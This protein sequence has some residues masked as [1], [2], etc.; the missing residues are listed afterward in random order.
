MPVGGQKKGQRAQA[1]SCEED[2]AWVGRR[3]RGEV[4]V[5]GRLAAAP[6]VLTYLCLGRRVLNIQNQLL[7][8]CLSGIYKKIKRLLSLSKT[9]RKSKLSFRDR[10]W[11]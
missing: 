3:K 9:V 6:T 5:E 11:R 7:Y 4:A 1:K 8:F 10:E 2:L